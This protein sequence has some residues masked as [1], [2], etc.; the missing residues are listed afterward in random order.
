MTDQLMDLLERGVNALENLAKD[1]EIQIPAFPAVCPHCEQMNPPVRVD[2]SE[3]E[4]RLAEFVIKAR[5]LMC[6]KVFYALP[7]QWIVAR[8]VEEAEIAAK[9]RAENSGYSS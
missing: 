1:P 6:S 3:G 4:G 2:E 9:E 5:C 7:M 8:T